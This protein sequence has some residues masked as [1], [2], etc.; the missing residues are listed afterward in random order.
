MSTTLSPVTIKMFDAQRV[1]GVFVEG[2]QSIF[3]VRGSIAFSNGEVELF[4]DVRPGGERKSIKLKVAERG[5]IRGGME[6][7]FICV[8]EDGQFVGV[9]ATQHRK[10][11][12]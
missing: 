10:Q 9:I 7:K 8:R 12:G 6:P 3:A 1:D 11:G 5:V 4:G 2:R